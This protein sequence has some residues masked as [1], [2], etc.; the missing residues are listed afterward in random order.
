MRQIPNALSLFRLFAS[1]FLAWLI[2]TSK[3]RLALAL[4]IL[5]GITDWLDGFAARKLGVSGQVGIVLDPLSDKVMLVVLFV[6]VAY[7][8]LIPMWLLWLAIVRDLVIVGGSYL[9]RIFRNIRKFTPSVLGKVS[10]FFQIVLMLMVLLYACFELRFF[11]WLQELALALAA[12]F[13]ALSGLDYVR[14]GIILTRG[15]VL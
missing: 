6:A 9:L 4:V 8:R 7:A 3:F 10:T 2:I 12:F 14:R 15:P 11:F 13:T 1:P 5:A